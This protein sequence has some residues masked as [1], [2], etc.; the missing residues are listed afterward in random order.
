M[1]LSLLPR[2]SRLL[3]AHPPVRRVPR[4]ALVH[5][6][7]EERVPPRGIALLHE[8]RVHPL[9]LHEHA[10]RPRVAPY[11]G[12]LAEDSPS[13]PQSPLNRRPR[14]HLSLRRRGS[15]ECRSTPTTHDL[16]ARPMVSI[17]RYLS[18]LARPPTGSGDHGP[19]RSRG[20]TPT[21]RG[22]SWCLYSES[23][24]RDTHDPH[25]PASPLACD[26]GT[27]ASAPPG[28]AAGRKK[29]DATSKTHPH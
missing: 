15:R 4:P 28:G 26:H 25:S 10:A 3:V 6:H 12:R 5:R 21:T 17:L 13:R 18:P 16:R 29:A 19:P 22:P 20:P 2:C 27:A 9:P 8:P 1:T 7:R 14:S 23:A 24:P 11:A